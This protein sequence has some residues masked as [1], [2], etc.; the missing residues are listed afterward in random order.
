MISRFIGT[1]CKL[2]LITKAE[3]LSERYKT[4]PKHID[5]E[6]HPDLNIITTSTWNFQNNIFIAI[7]IVIMQFSSTLTYVAV[8]FG[9]IGVALSSPIADANNPFLE[10]WKVVLQIQD[11]RSNIS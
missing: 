6:L 5:I 4:A 3:I 10:V 8:A 1:G 7:T 11:L 2:T 9:F